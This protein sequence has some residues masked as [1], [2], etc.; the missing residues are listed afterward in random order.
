MD[1]SALYAEVC[2]D[3]PPRSFR[4]QII[5]SF[6]PRAN[7][8][9]EIRRARDGA[10]RTEPPEELNRNDTSRP[11]APAMRVVTARVVVL[12][13][14]RSRSVTSRSRAH[15]RGRGAPSRA[16]EDRARRCSTQKHD[17]DARDRPTADA[18]LDER[19]TRGRGVFSRTSTTARIDGG[20]DRARGGDDFGRGRVGALP[21]ALRD[22]GFAPSAAVIAAC[23]MFFSATGLCVLEVN[24]DDVR[25]R[26]RR[27][28]R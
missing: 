16:R 3:A 22:A 24:L 11:T 27:G 21:V 15:L 6:T 9:R 28:C 12:D 13:H 4:D 23:W 17:V 1:S 18:S 25:T 26:T 5:A 10:I 14:V 20:G 8:A 7:G 19:G 2:G